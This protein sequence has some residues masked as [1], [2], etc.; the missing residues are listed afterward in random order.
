MQKQ[1]ICANLLK[2]GLL[3]QIRNQYNI[4]NYQKNNMKMKMINKLNINNLKTQKM[5]FY[6]WE[7]NQASLE[8]MPN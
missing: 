6:K 7:S 3:E 4:Q 2:A 1:I 8:K 5:K